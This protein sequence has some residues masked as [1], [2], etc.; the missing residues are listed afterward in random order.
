MLADH[1]ALDTN[2]EYLLQIPYDH[3]LQTE[4]HFLAV[5]LQ[6][7]MYCRMIQGTI[8]SAEGAGAVPSSQKNLNDSWM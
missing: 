7:Q 1:Q 6:L 5:S 8:T 3:L 2:L 4:V